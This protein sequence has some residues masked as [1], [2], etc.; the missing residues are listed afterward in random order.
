MKTEESGS[1]EATYLDG[2]DIIHEIDMMGEV[3]STYSNCNQ[4]SEGKVMKVY[5]KIWAIALII[6]MLVT[7][8]Y[9]SIERENDGKEILPPYSSPYDIDVV[10]TIEKEEYQHSEPIYV[11]VS[12]LNSGSVDLEIRKPVYGNNIRFFLSLSNGKNISQGIGFNPDGDL[13]NIS[14][15]KG[16]QVEWDWG[17]FLN[18][19]GLSSICSYRE[20]RNGLPVGTYSFIVKYYNYDTYEIGINDF[21]NQTYTSNRVT[22]SIV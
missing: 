17:E 22:I 2:K 9:F 16:R 12:I 13:Q 18:I 15:R 1:Y 8:I 4:T 19:N 20:F 3:G 14:L 21:P 6:I 10:L 11:K 7:V 5:I